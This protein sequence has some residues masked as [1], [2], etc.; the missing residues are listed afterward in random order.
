MLVKTHRYARRVKRV[1]AQCL[2]VWNGI[3]DEELEHVRWLRKCTTCHLLVFSCDLG[4]IYQ[5]HVAI[6]EEERHQPGDERT[7]GE[8]IRP[9]DPIETVLPSGLDD[10]RMRLARVFNNSGSSEGEARVHYRSA[11]RTACRCFATGAFSL[12]M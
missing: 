3:R 6:N 12:L 11:R 5:K 8:M 9:A 1:E 7:Y 10:I 2:A 4:M